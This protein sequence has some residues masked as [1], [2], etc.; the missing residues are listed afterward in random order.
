MSY[1]T[2]GTISIYYDHYA[3]LIQIKACAHFG[4]SEV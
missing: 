2:I 3:Q 1:D 4:P